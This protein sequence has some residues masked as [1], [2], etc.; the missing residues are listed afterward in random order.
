MKYLFFKNNPTSKFQSMAV[1]IFLFLGC[2]NVMAQE[3]DTESYH[4]FLKEGKTW[5][6]EDWYYDLNRKEEWTKIV[7]YVINGT[8]EINGKTYYNLYRVSEDGNEL[9]DNLREEDRKVW[10][11]TENGDYLLYDF[12]MS[13]GDSYMPINEW[14]V[15]TLTAIFPVQFHDVTLNVFLYN[16]RIERLEDL[17]ENVSCPI[18][19]GVGCDEGFDISRYGWGYAPIDGIANRE[20]FLS[21]YED[22]KCICTI[23][24]IESVRTSIQHPQVAGNEKE[25]VPNYYSLFGQ[26]HPTLQRGINIVRTAEGKIKKVIVK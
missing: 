18:I 20:N 25:G 10:A 24:D 17:F 2:M 16:E 12:S 23:E 7:S 1:F 22:G 15:F 9:Y 11:Y 3:D 26:Q 14:R 6:Y 21:C 19:E 13:V 8:T 4:P 5:Y